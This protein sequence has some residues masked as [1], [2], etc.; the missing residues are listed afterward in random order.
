MG[1]AAARGQQVR[2]QLRRAAVELIAEQGWRGVST[3]AVADRAGV[4][5]GLVHYHFASLEALLREAA[6]AVLRE[7]AD[8]LDDLLDRADDPRAAVRLV[9]GSLAGASGRDPVSLV[10]IETYLAATRDPQLRADVAD[11]VA[12]F[13]QRLARRLARHGVADP[14][15]TAAVLAAAVDGLLLHRGLDAELTAEYVG[16]VLDRVTTPPPAGGGGPGCE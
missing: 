3:R 16:P 8:G 5:A 15:R 12:G 9:L 6:T 11:V 4:G 13:R 7:A 1:T 14:E 10:F 2:D